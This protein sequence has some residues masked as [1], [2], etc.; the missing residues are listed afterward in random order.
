MQSLSTLL[1][2]FTNFTQNISGAN[3]SLGLS[4]LSEQQRLLLEQYF[5]NERQFSTITIGA[6]N[7]AIT[8][9]LDASALSATLTGTWKYSNG[10][11]SVTFTNT[12]GTTYSLTANAAN[13]ATSAT[14][15]S[16]WTGPTGLQSITFTNSNSD[17]RDVTFT[18]GSTAISWSPPLTGATTST[19][20]TTNDTSQIIQVDFTNGSTTIEWTTPL[21]YSIT[22]TAISTGGFQ[23]YKIP[24]NISKITNSTVSV[25]QLR[26]VPFP[27]QT[28]NDWDRL[29]F[30]PYSS[31]IP[32]YFYL[33]NG[34]ME[35]WPV[36]STTG[37]T[38]TFNYKSRVPDF[39]TAFLFSDNAGTAY[40]AGQT[41]YDYQA[42]AITTATVGSTT[43]TG[44]STSWNTTGKFPLNVDVT[45]YNLFLVINPPYG[46]GIWY[47]IQQFNSD[48]SLELITPIGSA[49]AVSN[50]SH[51]YSIAQLPI[52]NEDFH[53]LINYKALLFYFSSIVS[54]PNKYKQFEVLVQERETKLAEWAGEKFV[55]YNLGGEP[56]LLNPNNYPYYTGNVQ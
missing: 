2:N 15:S 25:G 48:T 13:G 14:L 28:R 19:T 52:L 12:G 46:D 54:D 6:M 49:P 47:P 38:I 17:V 45:G 7:L 30:L 9:N 41:V 16:N 3:Q 50:V 36:P 33:Y 56:A 43:I 42:G 44:T 10:T 18:N 40:V 11:Q 29:N 32:N 35:L 53:P 34:Y 23:K 1:N 4:L 26:F 8:A 20:I 27:V 37:N 39:T 5:D 51:N 55:N 22:D 21:T 31:D 24:S